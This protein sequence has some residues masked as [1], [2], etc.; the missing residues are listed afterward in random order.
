VTVSPGY[1][2]EDEAAIAHGLE[3]AQGFV[4]EHTH[5]SERD[6]LRCAIRGALQFRARQGAGQ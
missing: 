4:D 3:C 6:V 2:D 5:Y 1:S